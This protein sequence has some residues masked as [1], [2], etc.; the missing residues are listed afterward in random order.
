PDGFAE[1]TTYYVTVVPYN[2]AGDATD[3][4]E[5]SFTT[6]TLLVPPGCTVITNP[7][8]GASSALLDEGITWTAVESADGYRISIGTTLGGRDIVDNETVT[9][10]RFVPAVD[11]AENTAYYITVIPFN[12][13]GEATGC[14]YTRFIIIPDENI[15]RT[16]Y[17]FSPNGDGINDFW[18]I[19]GI[20]DYPDNKVS[21]Y[22]RWGDMVFQIE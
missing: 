3:C 6:E 16:K 13:A 19:E 8:D 17:G 10:T 4:P 5:I 12:S 2:A 18:K 22:N 7:V 14:G 11:F 20:G 21:I 9:G 1:N 15:N